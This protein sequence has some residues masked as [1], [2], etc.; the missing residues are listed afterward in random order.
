MVP[1]S[2]FSRTGRGAWAQLDAAGREAAVEH[3]A[4]NGRAFGL[5]CAR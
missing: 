5:V 3:A 2:S 1:L 4:S